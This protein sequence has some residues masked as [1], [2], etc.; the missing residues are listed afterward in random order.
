[1]PKLNEDWLAT[2]VG[3]LI[4]ASAGLGLFG[5]GPQT[6]SIT[7]APEETASTDI[8]GTGGWSVSARMGDK[9]ITV[10]DAYTRLYD[11][12]AYSYVCENGEVSASGEDLTLS[13]QDALVSLTNNC[14]SALTL[15][16]RKGNA[17]PWPLFGLFQ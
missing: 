1:M 16:Y 15:T 14:D 13:L 6:M 5:S 10:I 17:I 8:N 12:T 11:S 2:I 3:L 7:A 4:V 9:T